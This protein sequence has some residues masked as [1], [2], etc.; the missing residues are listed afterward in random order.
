MEYIAKNLGSNKVVIPISSNE[1]EETC[2]YVE[3]ENLF[4]KIENLADVY[5]ELKPNNTV[6]RKQN[7][8]NPSPQSRS[9]VVSKPSQKLVGFIG[10]MESILESIDPTLSLLPNDSKHGNIVTFLKQLTSFVEMSGKVAGFD[11]NKVG[12]QIQSQ[13]FDVCFCISEFIKKSIV[14]KHANS[15]T[16]DIYGTNDE[17]ILISHTNDTYNL[18]SSGNL[19]DV[20]RQI[21]KERIAQYDKD[22]LLQKLNSLLV[23][24]LKEIAE[25]LDIPLFKTEDGKKKTYLKNEL[26]DLI[27]TKIVENTQ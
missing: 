4:G 23:K 25:K 27:K 18:E 12:A 5:R 3:E 15:T 13:S 6:R 7:V 16:W 14:I 10:L 22:G 20:K 17:C 21:I 11:K 24:D 1:F 26:K 2:P 9:S 8:I 19:C